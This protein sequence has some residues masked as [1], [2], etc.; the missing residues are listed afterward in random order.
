MSQSLENRIDYLGLYGSAISGAEIDDPSG[1]RSDPARRL[2]PASP[3]LQPARP[4]QLCGRGAFGSGVHSCGD[5]SCVARRYSGGSYVAAG[6]GAC[7]CAEPLAT[8]VRIRPNKPSQPPSACNTVYRARML[9]GSPYEL[10]WREWGRSRPR[11]VQPC[12]RG[13]P[14]PRNNGPRGRHDI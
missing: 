6:S 5:R 10:R 4:Q 8:V 1:L 2:Q 9:G 7:S 14:P 12:S 11:W 13:P 3:Q